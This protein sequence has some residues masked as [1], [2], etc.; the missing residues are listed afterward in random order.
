MD[1]R[2]KF[3]DPNEKVGNATCGV[4]D[5]AF[6][7][8]MGNKLFQIYQCPVCNHSWAQIIRFDHF[9]IGE[10]KWWQ[11]I[12]ASYAN[13]SK[14]NFHM[15]M[16]MRLAVDFFVKR[17][18]IDK[19]GVISCQE[20]IDSADLLLKQCLEDGW[21][22]NRLVIDKDTGDRLPFMCFNHYAAWM[23]KKYGVNRAKS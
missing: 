22:L 13:I 21:P 3:R 17:N 8:E 16:D 14:F 4:C 6:P 15:M 19:C 12:S 23:G 18:K 10:P 7:T 1:N 9:R 20:N 11:F 5:N 2:E